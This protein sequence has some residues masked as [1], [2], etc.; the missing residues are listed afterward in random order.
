MYV[1]C[2]SCKIILKIAENNDKTEYLAVIK[3]AMVQTFLI[4]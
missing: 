2:V 3:L 1:V 4:N